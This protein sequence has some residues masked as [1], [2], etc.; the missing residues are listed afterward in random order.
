MTQ[1]WTSDSYRLGSGK[2]DRPPYPLVYRWRHSIC[3]WWDGSTPP[4]STRL[5]KS[6]NP[7]IHSKNS[8]P[9]NRALGRF[10]DLRMLQLNFPPLT[11]NSRKKFLYNKALATTLD[12]SRKFLAQS[13]AR[14][15]HQPSD[16][17]DRPQ[18]ESPEN[19][20]CWAHGGYLLYTIV[21]V[22][23][24]MMYVIYHMM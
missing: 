22:I 5:K 2:R 8:Q 24:Y 16:T 19:A 12:G 3:W 15:L 14:S 20:G 7:K 6:K 10:R 9:Q 11:W 17:I 18:S 13:L 21:H 23:C 1:I 4:L